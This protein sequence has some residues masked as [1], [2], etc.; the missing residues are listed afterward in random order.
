MADKERFSKKH[1]EYHSDRSNV[2]R[3]RGMDRIGLSTFPKYGK[4][5]PEEPKRHIK[6]AAKALTF[7][8]RQRHDRKSVPD[9]W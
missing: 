3:D 9:Q 1:R 5:I 2:A 8:F 7:R 4:A 6:L